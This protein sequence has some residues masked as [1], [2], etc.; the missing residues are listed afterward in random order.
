MALLGV[1]FAFS[2]GKRG[3]LVGIAISIEIA[4]IY[5]GAVGAS[6]SLGYVGFLNGPL[7]AW[8]P[9]LIFGLVSVYLLFKL[10]T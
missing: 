4:M 9:N 8:S 10:R 5:W 6:R 2:M 3:T 7:S 1:P